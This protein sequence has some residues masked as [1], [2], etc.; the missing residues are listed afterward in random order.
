MR[1]DLGAL[2]HDAN[3]DL[4]LGCGGELLQ[5]DCRGEAGGPGSDHDDV[6][7]HPFALGPLFDHYSFL[8]IRGTTISDRRRSVA[9]VASQG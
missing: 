2:L 8:G 9:V 1:P 7:F 3:A 6:V 5:T 4:A